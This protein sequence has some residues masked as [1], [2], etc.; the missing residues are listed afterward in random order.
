MIQRLAT[1]FRRNPLLAV[2]VLIAVV[3]VVV[4]AGFSASD[5]AKTILIAS[6]QHDSEIYSL[7][8]NGEARRYDYLP[9]V[10]SQ[11]PDVITLMSNPALKDR[12][13]Q[14]LEELNHRAG[15]SV[16]YVL[17]TK[18]ETLA[19]SN[20][21]SSGSFVGNNYKDRPYFKDAIAGGKGVFHG[22]G[23]TTK[24]P[25]LFM[26]TPISQDDKIIG[27][28]VVKVDLDKIR[29]IWANAREPVALL[30]S[31]GVVFLSSEPEWMYKTTRDLTQDD[32]QW[33]KSTGQ[34]PS[35]AKFDRLPWAT[36]NSGND[37]PV[38]IDAVIQGRKRSFLATE[39]DFPALRWKLMV[40]SNYDAV[41]KARNQILTIASMLGL[42]VGVLVL[43]TW[44]RELH[45]ER[46]FRRAME[47]S[48][49]IGMRARDIDGRIIYVN[50]ALCEMVGYS[51]EDLMGK[52]PPYPYWQSENIEKHWKDNDAA[53]SGRAARDG[54]ESR[55]R[56]K[57][58]HEVI[59]MIY[60]AP[61]T[62][63]DG[64]QLGWM[65]SIVDIS[66]QR[67]S[68]ELVQEHQDRL[69]RVSRLTLVGE[70]ASTMAHELNQ[71]LQALS[72]YATAAKD[73]SLQSSDA[74]MKHILEEILAQ[75]QR[76]GRVV[77]KIRPEK[78]LGLSKS[79]IGL[80]ISE[81]LD[82]LKPEIQKRRVEVVVECDP[83]LPSILID[84]VLIEHVLV[85]LVMNAVQAMNEMPVTQRSI[86]VATQLI[87]DTV[88]VSV[89]DRG[90]GVGRQD[91]ERIFTPFFTSKQDG[92]GLGLNICRS[93]LERHGGSIAF[94][95]LPSGGA[96]FFFT[97]PVAL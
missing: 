81:V 35:D 77:K 89:S 57:D 47:G 46:A 18:G 70:M 22:V 96:S 52:L 19:S 45:K 12:T 59:T 74:K 33:I 84:R 4:V 66:E 49:K 79:D 23:L 64:R 17:N 34:Y 92:L 37:L 55:I 24:I 32:L 42:V 6:V 76:L 51:K 5:R 14:Y 53:M 61:L 15:S 78:A 73:L 10:A 31:H 39:A 87:S 97:I 56:H 71:P 25:G 67:R 60:T 93:I 85:N 29:E 62:D 16:L 1:A 36:A 7:G 82:F 38:L 58:G 40:M 13:N 69:Q 41:A 75:V 21:R 83:N 3:V 28:A 11:H 91:A 26:S 48:L 65:S 20:W 44:N 2:F 54:F 88:R 86:T 43:F 50:P 68:F 90:V 27:V 72:G 9:Y 63:A 80:L 95:N 30:D 94:E 8:L